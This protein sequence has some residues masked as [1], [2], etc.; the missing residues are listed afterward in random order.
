MAG[1]WGGAVFSLCYVQF[2]GC[3]IRTFSG[4]W[5]D[6]RVGLYAY[7]FLVCHAGHAIRGGVANPFRPPDKSVLFCELLQ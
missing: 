1:G 4:G 5:E 6:G 2:V 3:V 7:D